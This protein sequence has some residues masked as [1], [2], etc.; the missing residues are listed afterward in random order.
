MTKLILI[1]AATLSATA[2]LA[3]SKPSSRMPAADL[4]WEQPMGAGGP[5]VAFA[6]GDGKSKGPAEFFLKFPAG[7]DSGWHTHDANYSA[8]VIKGTMTAQA[9]GD[10]EIQLPSGS[11]FG[12]PGKKNHRNSCTKDSDCV[13]FVHSEKGFTFHPMTAEGKP[14][15]A[16]DKKAEGAAT[17]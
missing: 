16:P 17:K 13:I 2:A 11:Y 7:F 14:A 4:K 5:S 3:A 12:E 10:A 6:S 15:P 1:A 8:V 9:Q